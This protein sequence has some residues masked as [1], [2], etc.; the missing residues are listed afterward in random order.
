MAFEK[1]VALIFAGTQG[2]L[3]DVAVAQV[4][5]FGKNLLD[6]LEKMHQDSILKKIKESGDLTDEVAEKLK[7]A[8]GDFKRLR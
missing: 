7:G 4:G 3:D 2:Y 1:Q 6:Y 5:Q 8:I